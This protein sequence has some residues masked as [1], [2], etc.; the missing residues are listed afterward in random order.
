MHDPGVG[1]WTWQAGFGLLGGALV[2]LA[3]LVPAVVVQ[4]RRYGRISGARL[5]GLL[6]VSVYVVALVAYVF[7]PLPDPDTVCNRR[8]GPGLA[9]FQW[10]PFSF[11]DDIRSTAARRGWRAALTGWS[12][13]QVLFNVALFIP[14]G[15][16]VRRYL[17]RGI[18]AATG[19]GLA[20]SAVIEFTQWSAIFGLYPCSYRV[21]DVDDLIANTT[22]ALV[23][24]VIAPALLFWM[25]Q[26]RDLR[27]TRTEPRPVTVGRRWVGMLLDGAAFLLVAVALVAGTVAVRS[28][29]AGRFLDAPVWASPAAAVI[30]GLVVFYLPALRGSGASIGQALVWLSPRWPE[31]SSDRR[32]LR[33]SVTGGVFTVGQVAGAVS[34]SGAAGWVQITCWVW[35][36]L[37]LLAVPF[38]TA[39]RGR[40]G[41]SGLVSGAAM[42]DVRASVVARTDDRP[43]GAARLVG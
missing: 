1:G 8:G 35:T 30:A 25:P 32:L 42:V 21:G 28:A 39:A 27:M 12:L 16:V 19:I 22:G 37:C 41:L 4:Y 33:A 10:S 5:L 9:A 20:V 15:V 34:G 31:P 17:G 38:T 3:V 7:L 36:V 40:P 2:F 24:A 18:V 11:V 14:L 43:D 26:A 29:L 13:W 6:A 23:G